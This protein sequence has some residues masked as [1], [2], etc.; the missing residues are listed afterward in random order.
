MGSVG[1]HKTLPWAEASH[2]SIATGE[3][4]QKHVPTGCSRADKAPHPA[5]LGSLHA[6]LLS[7]LDCLSSSFLYTL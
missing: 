5:H 3:R 1:V 7:G 2:L 6:V 4:K